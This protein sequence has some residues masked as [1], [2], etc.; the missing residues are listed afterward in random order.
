MKTFGFVGYEGS[1]MVYRLRYTDLTLGY[2][3]LSYF[4]SYGL[5]GIATEYDG[6][7]GRTLR[8]EVLT[9]TTIPIAHAKVLTA[10]AN[11]QKLQTKKVLIQ[12]SL[13]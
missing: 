6:K 4:K 5:H 1:H 9:L 10:E 11:I 12:Q 13:F 8:I 3:V 7:T 2:K